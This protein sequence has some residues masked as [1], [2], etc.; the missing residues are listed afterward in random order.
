MTDLINGLKVIDADTHVVEPY[1]LWTSRIS[2]KRWGD[3]V[4]HILRD[5]ESGKDMWVAGDTPL[6]LA[7]APAQAGYSQYPPDCPPTLMDADPATWD[8]NHRLKRM[9][10]AGVYAQILYP[11]VAGMGTGNFS[12]MQ[13]PELMLACVRAYNDFL[14]D[15]ASTAPNRFIPISALPFWDIQ[16]TLE[17]MQ[18]CVEM[19]HRGVIFSAQP[20]SWGQPWLTDPHWNPIWAQAQEMSLP[21]NFHIASGPID[22][23]AYEGNGRHANYA[24]LATLLFMGN[25]RAIVDVIIGGICHRFPALNFV[26]VES[27]VSW[28]PFVLQALD[29]QWRNFGAHLE[30]PDF[31]LLPS[32]YFRRQV[33]GCF[34]FERGESLRAALDCLGPDNIL[35]ESDFPH[36]T[37]MSPGPATEAVEPR[38]YITRELVPLVSPD[39]LR[40]LVHDNATR[41]YNLP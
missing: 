32:E 33:Y 13:D 10:Q 11:N 4:P 41:V 7:G 36:P 29:W 2:V 25:A 24:R 8:P 39:V 30:H 23:A 16:T 15:F 22:L 27:G 19:G 28:I 9:D 17:E 34:W 1:D 31:D 26:S 38:E 20:E 40:K 6:G 3:L 18:R 12:A 21:I 14:T 35:Y 37:C 5:S